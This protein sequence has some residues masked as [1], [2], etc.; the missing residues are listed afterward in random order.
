M[1]VNE[2]VN[3]GFWDSAKVAY[4]AGKAA[5]N[6]KKQEQA[7]AV[8]T[9][10]LAATQKQ[11]EVEIGKKRQAEWDA[12]H[13]ATPNP[14]LPPTVAASRT[15]Q[16]K[17]AVTKV[18]ANSL[19]AVNKPRTKPNTDSVLAKP[20]TQQQPITI[21]KDKIMPTDPRYKTIMAAISANA[22]A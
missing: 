13:G 15:P 18:A 19:N 2:V 8:R 1:R 12:K 4:N 6:K 10:D 20:V 3:E 16:E 9:A 7:N 5:L 21:G 17:T 14:L 22:A 11:T